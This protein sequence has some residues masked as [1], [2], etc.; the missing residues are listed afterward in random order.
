MNI[1]TI[2]NS[3]IYYAHTHADYELLKL[4]AWLYTADEFKMWAWIFRAIVYYIIYPQNHY[5]A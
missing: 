5:K 1:N 4:K 2:I 3:Q